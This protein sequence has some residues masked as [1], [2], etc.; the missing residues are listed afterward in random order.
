MLAELKMDLDNK[1][2]GVVVRHIGGLV[3]KNGDVAHGLSGAVGACLLAY[4]TPLT[5]KGGQFSGCK[6]TDSLGA[7]RALSFQLSGDSTT[8]NGLFISKTKFINNTGGYGGAIVMFPGV[9][10]VSACTGVV[11][12]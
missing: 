6:S 2:G 12:R 3:I 10:Q 9:P 11:V 8:S 4:N 5:I 1:G 7:S